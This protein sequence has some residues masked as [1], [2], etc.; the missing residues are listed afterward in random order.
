[1]QCGIVSPQKGSRGGPQA[2]ADGLGDIGRRS[3]AGHHDAGAARTVMGDQRFAVGAGTMVGRAGH[4][5]EGG[6]RAGDSVLVPARVDKAADDHGQGAQ[7]GDKT[8]A[9]S[10]NLCA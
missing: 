10:R 2:V 3:E 7:D 1:M 5:L 4:H 8:P 9:G 6:G